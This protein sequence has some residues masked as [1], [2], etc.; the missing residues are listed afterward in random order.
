MNY[1]S[2]A[3]ENYV[4]L[5]YGQVMLF[6]KGSEVSAINAGLFGTNSKSF[7]ISLTNIQQSFDIGLA[8]FEKLQ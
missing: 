6:Q 8:C 7:S 1:G 3:D 2:L 5:A 4:D